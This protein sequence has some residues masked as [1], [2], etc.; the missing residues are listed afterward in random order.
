MGKPFLLFASCIGTLLLACGGAT[1]TTRDIEG[2]NLSAKA[3]AAGPEAHA[4]S[5]LV[6]GLAEV[7]MGRSDACM[8]NLKDVTRASPDSRTQF[9]MKAYFE[10]GGTCPAKGNLDAYAVLMPDD[11]IVMLIEECD[12]AGPDPLFS[13][14]LAKERTS[15]LFSDYILLRLHMDHLAR[16]AHKT[17]TPEAKAG[18]EEIE[19]S[20]P[21]LA[22][23]MKARGL[24]EKKEQEEWEA[25][26]P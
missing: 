17:G 2:A 6:A 14:E 8:R 11:K 15:F 5:L 23:S 13:G 25:N 18:L 22:A 26:N 20:A 7:P 21:K 24:A 9:L 16:A 3:V 1:L 19:A 4:F 12:A 10:C